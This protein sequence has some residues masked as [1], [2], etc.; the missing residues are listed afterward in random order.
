DKHVIYVWVDAL[1]NYATAVGYGANQEKFDATFPA[2]VHLIGKDILRFH[3]VIWPAMLM[4][5]GLPLPGK[6][7][8]NGWLMVGGEKMSKSNL[9]GIKPQDL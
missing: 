5:Q 3:S 4:A 2:N 7:V 6:V 9:T 1:L 8:A